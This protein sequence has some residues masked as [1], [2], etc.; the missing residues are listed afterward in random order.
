MT[1]YEAS[2]LYI[3]LVDIFVSSRKCT[4]AHW[5]LSLVSH[6][7]ALPKTIQVTDIVMVVLLLRAAS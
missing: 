7:D 2:L 1:V 3:L 6:K 5:E 4:A